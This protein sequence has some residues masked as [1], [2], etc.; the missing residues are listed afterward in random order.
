MS[1]NHIL[2]D[3]EVVALLKGVSSKDAK[4]S[5]F[6]VPENGNMSLSAWNEKNISVNKTAL[7]NVTELTWAECEREINSFLRKKTLVR[8]DTAKFGPMS[9]CLSDKMEKYAYSVFQMQPVGQYGLAAIDYLCLDNVIHMLFGS[10]KVLQEC[11]M[12]APGKI[13][14]I[15]AGKFTRAVMAGFSSACREYNNVTCEPVKT[16]LKPNLI[17]KLSPEEQVYCI[18]LIV[19]FGEVDTKMSIIVTEKFLQD[20]IPVET[21][22]VKFVEKNFWRRAIENEVSDSYVS[23]SVSLPNVNIKMNEFMAMKEG[24]L[25]EISDPTMAYVCLNDVKLFRAAAGQVEANRVAKIISEI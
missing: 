2:S 4:S 11:D 21:A 24:S 15:I 3:D 18:D 23:L 25:I 9:E 22:D 1:D 13:G 8:F 16:V 17:I 20:F 10:G 6:S 7:N 5:V 19:T 14:T 12:L